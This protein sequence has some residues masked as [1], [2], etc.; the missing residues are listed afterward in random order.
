MNKKKVPDFLAALI[1]FGGVLAYYHFRYENF[2]QKILENKAMT[3]ATVIKCS[4]KNKHG[5]VVDYK[6]HDSNRNVYFG[7]ISGDEYRVLRKSIID[8]SFPLIY[9]STNPKR[10]WILIL[11]DEFELYG[12]DFPDSL[13][14]VIQ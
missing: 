5:Y 6:F 13:N 9:D 4:Y 2:M 10:N 12:L 11:P 14:W 1:V 8:K 3:T 7:Y